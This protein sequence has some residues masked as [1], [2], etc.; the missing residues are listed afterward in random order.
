MILSEFW[1]FCEISSLILSTVNWF[2]Q[3]KMY[4]LNIFALIETKF[5]IV[6]FQSS[7]EQ[8]QLG[9]QYLL[10]WGAFFTRYI[11]MPLPI[12][13]YQFWG[14]LKNLC[15]P[16]LWLPHQC[17]I[18]GQRW[19]GGRWRPAW[20]E[21]YFSFS[22]SLNSSKFRTLT[23]SFSLSSSRLGLQSIE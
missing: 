21:T 1:H 16:P 20:G 4:F 3:I 11:I 5:L 18:L 15:F 22:S 6:D 7:H 23:F 8:S 19:L 17:N 14:I 12:T 10:Y 13:P 2:S 9:G